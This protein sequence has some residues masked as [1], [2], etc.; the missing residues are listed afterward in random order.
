MIRAPRGSTPANNRVVL[1]DKRHAVYLEVYPDQDIFVHFR[2]SCTHLH[3]QGIF[4]LNQIINK[5][6]SRA[7]CS[8][9]ITFYVEHKVVENLILN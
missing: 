5:F 7:T 2:N 3:C 8:T 9:C 6:K 4:G 1:L